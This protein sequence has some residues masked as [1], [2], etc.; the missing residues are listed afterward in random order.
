MTTHG[1]RITVES[2]YQPS[3]SEPQRGMF[4]HVYDIQIENRNAF[5]V[6]LL[7]RHWIITE[8]DGGRKEVKGPGVIGLQPVI[9]AGAMHAYSSYCV[10]SSD[11]GRMEG[12][13]TMRRVDDDTRFEVIIPPFT[14]ALPERMN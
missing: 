12:T 6:Q 3:H 7:F 5:A 8:S 14:L 9:A 10:L 2:Q 1:I 4:L 11:I 13:Y